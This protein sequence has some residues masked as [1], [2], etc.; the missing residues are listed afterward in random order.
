MPWCIENYLLRELDG[1]SR[2]PSGI[3]TIAHAKSGS[4]RLSLDRAGSY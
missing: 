2:L 4:E 3:D 1:L